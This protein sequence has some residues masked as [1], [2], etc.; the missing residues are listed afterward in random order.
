MSFGFLSIQFGFA[1]QN[2]NMSRIF[3]TLGAKIDNIAILWIAVPVTSLI[4]QRIVGRESDKI[5][6]CSGWLRPKYI[7]GVILST[8][9]LLIMTNS[10][11]L[12]IAA[13]LLWIWGASINFTLVPFC[14][15]VSDMLPIGQRSFCF[16]MRSFLICLGGV[17]ASALPWI[18][19]NWFNVTSEIVSG[20]G[21]T[22][23]VKLSFYFGGAIF[24]WSVLWTFYSNQKLFPENQADFEAGKMV[25]LKVTE[26]SFISPVNLLPRFI[27]IGFIF[28]T[29]GI[30]G[31][32]L[33]QQMSWD[34]ALY[35][36]SIGL[37]V[38]GL[39]LLV[40]AWYIRQG[41]I[42]NSLVEVITELMNVSKSMKKLAIV[43]FF[44]WFALF[45]MWIYSTSAVTGHIYGTSDTATALYNEG[46]NWVGVLF[47]TYN[48]F[49]LFVAFFIPFLIKWTSRKKA[50]TIALFCGGIGLVS[51][52]FV[53]DPHILV[54]SMLGVGFAW[55]SILSQPFVILDESLPIQ[56]RR[57]YWGLLN[58]FIAISQILAASILS[59][60]INVFFHGNAIYALILGGASFIIAALSVLFVD[61]FDQQ[62]N[63][64]TI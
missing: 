34:N 1:L 8:L 48:G 3:E 40:S 35:V 46:A 59:F 47:A 52:Y 15:F 39:I 57:N 6:T 64:I 54:V 19:T 27:R 12:W 25:S 16:P 43:Q 53:K 36:I 17:V 18:F 49:A 61:D 45:D 30:L 10:S 22:Q 28:L 58:F 60:F 33:I 37:A 24:F 55:A 31:S 11:S 14:A 5:W 13:G 20:E 29:I 50:H 23:S 44:S 9:T 26:H 4:I 32:I 21:M 63:D 2:A 38:F 7:V 41:L 62:A 56:K 42:H 51:F